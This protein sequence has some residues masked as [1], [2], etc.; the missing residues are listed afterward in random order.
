[1]K[2]SLK[3]ILALLLAFLMLFVSACAGGEK[4]EQSGDESASAE[5]QT[6]ETEKN[7]DIMI[8]FTSDVHCGVDRGFGYAG[9]YE[10]RK[11]FERKGYDVLLVDNGDAIQG[12][13]IGVATKGEAIINLMNALEYDAAIP[14]NHEFDYGMERFLELSEMTEFPYISCNFTHNGE[15]VF[16]P[17]IIKE[18][19]G[20][21]IAFVGV[22]TPLTLQTTHPRY[23]QDESGDYVYGFCGDETGEALYNAV[24]SAA[25]AARAEGAD[26]V[27][28]L[29]HLGME[30]DA[31]PWT[32]AEVIANTSGIDALLDG[33]SHDTEKVVMKNK[34]GES[35]LRAACGTKLGFIGACVIS[36]ENNTIDPQLYGWT[37]DISAP[38]LLGIDNEIGDKVSA[39]KSE[40]S[41]IMNLVVAHSAVELTVNYPDITTPEGEPIRMVRRAECNIG[42]LLADA[43]RDRSGADIAIA[44]GGSIRMSIHA[45]DVTTNDIINAVPFG[46]P[47]GVIEVTG[48]QLLD[49]LEWG[50]RSA[51][52]ETGAFP[53]VSGISFEVHTYIPSGCVSDENNM[54]T[55]VSGERR[56]KN[57]LVGG[58]PLDPDAAYT[59]AAIDYTLFDDG[60]GYTM[61]DGCRVI[62]DGIEL[63]YQALIGY[64][65][66]TLGGVIGEEYSDPYGDDRIIFVEEP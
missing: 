47:I 60:D 56:V 63:D 53:Q 19:A 12:E 27:I 14:G 29:G 55:G 17:Y 34:N 36:P 45:G 23:F 15:L 10:M 1:M 4:T 22:T 7:G 40:L 62:K 2:H 26:Y 52:S 31:S 21:K 35:V 3:I 51:P 48:Q 33:H 64:T 20:K 18:A 59:L 25:D 46:N 13:Y 41:E 61:F 38:E 65:E 37:N 54:F 5:A 11:S 58:E 42:D 8:L 9:L 32:Y 49:A 50:C 24:Q 6:P 28:V 44:V 43:Y 39:A 30:T 66:D 57:V 16:E